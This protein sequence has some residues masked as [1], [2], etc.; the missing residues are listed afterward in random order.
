MPLF[1]LQYRHT[2]RTS[3]FSN[4]TDG[5]YRRDWITNPAISPANAIQY[6]SLKWQILRYADV[7]LMFAE[8]ENELNGPYHGCL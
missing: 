5:K 7:L 8:A 4:M 2:N 1:Y 3:D 6:F